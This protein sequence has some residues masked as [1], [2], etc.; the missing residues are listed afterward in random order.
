MEE[1]CRQGSGELMMH[2]ACSVRKEDG[3][4]DEVYDTHETLEKMMHSEIEASQSFV[5]LRRHMAS[6]D[7]SRLGVPGWFSGGAEAHDFIF[8]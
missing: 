2:R 7:E 6:V 3:G 5:A 1:V 4:G 8:D